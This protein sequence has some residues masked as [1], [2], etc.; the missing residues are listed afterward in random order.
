MWLCQTNLR[1]SGNFICFFF[2]GGGGQ[3]DTKVD[4]ILYAHD[5]AWLDVGVVLI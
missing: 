4:Q 3:L 2:L 5:Y 1:Q